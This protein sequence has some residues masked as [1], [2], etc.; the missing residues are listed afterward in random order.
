MYDAIVIGARTAG[1][2][3]AMLLARKGYKVLLAERKAFPSDTISTHFL[4]HGAVVRLERWGLLPALIASGCPPIRRMTVDFGDI[5][6]SGSPPPS[7][8]VD[9]AYARAVTSST[10]FS[11]RPRANPAPKSTKD[12][13]SQ[14][15]SR[16]HPASPASSAAL[17]AAGY[18]NFTRKS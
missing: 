17:R 2:P 16:K 5:A 11:W 14:A 1:S 13:W 7:D 8:G 15:F 18:R 4:W 3:T 9:A 10:R 6:I 12:F